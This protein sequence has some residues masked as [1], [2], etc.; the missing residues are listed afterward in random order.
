MRTLRWTLTSVVLAAMVASLGFHAALAVPAPAPSV[1][2]VAVIV[3]DNF[4]A[5]P[6]RP[7]APLAAN[8]P[9]SP[10]DVNVVG[11]QGAGDDLPAGVAHGSVVYS[12]LSS[13][14]D[15]TAGLTRTAVRSKADYGADLEG[16]I[17]LKAWSYLKSQ[18]VLVA[19]DHDRSTTGDIA[20]RLRVLTEGMQGSAVG[21][22]R[23]V[24]NLS[25]VIAPCNVP[26][27][28]DGIGRFDVDATL[29][30]Y[31]EL[32]DGQPGLA[33]FQAA[34]DDL[35]NDTAGRKDRILRGDP[36]DGLEVIRRR[37]ALSEFY[38]EIAKQN[39]G[40]VRTRVFS[41]PLRVTLVEHMN[42]GGRRVVPVGA[43]GNGVLL[44]EDRPSPQRVRFEFPFAPALWNTVVSASASQKAFGT[45]A[46]YS[47]SGEVLLDGSLSLGTARLQGTSF[48]A[49]RL[50]ARQAAYLLTGGTATCNGYVPT[51]GYANSDL[52][53]ARWGNLSLST[54]ISAYCPDF[55]ARPTRP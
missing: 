10:E 40:P 26:Q 7:E 19:M 37:V 4:D 3:V 25:F 11:D 44:T 39:P 16:I 21:F 53:T 6:T 46:P 22:T 27:W 14:L 2:Y 24:L 55:N 35:V 36:I 1:G 43:A 17:D 41:D 47:N 31:Q 42:T 51:L 54:A 15:N 45:L 33:R 48:A 12:L 9:Y 30:A 20:E 38:G 5:E 13:E 28:L 8:C 32:I 49:P 29:R 52:Q 50:A 34:L 23:F 18:V